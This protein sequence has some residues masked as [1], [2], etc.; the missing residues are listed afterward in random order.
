[1]RDVYKKA[2]IHHLETVCE[3]VGSSANVGTSGGGTHWVSAG[4]GGI[5]NHRSRPRLG[6]R[7]LVDATRH[8]G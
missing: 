5:L 1:M 2:K 3:C 6:D 4:T 8:C 7:W